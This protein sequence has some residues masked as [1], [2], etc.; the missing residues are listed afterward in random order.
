MGYR[1]RHGQFDSLADQSVI[2][3]DN[4]SISR[5]SIPCIYD[6]MPPMPA[7]HTPPQHYGNMICFHEIDLIG[8]GYDHIEVALLD[9]PDGLTMTGA[10][11]GSV[12]SLVITAMCPDAER[13]TLS[14]PFSVFAVGSVGSDMI[15]PLRD[16]VTKG[17]LRVV[18][19]PIGE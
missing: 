2:S 10:I 17:V 1:L 19:G 14:V 9:C 5:V 13:A 15:A 8:E 16:V 6:C 3:V 12:V 18:A 4:G 11:D 7:P